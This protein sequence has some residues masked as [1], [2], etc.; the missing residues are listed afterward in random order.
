[1]DSVRRGGGL[2]MLMLLSEDLDLLFIRLRFH[3]HDNR[4]VLL[5][6]SPI[7]QSILISM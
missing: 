7:C 2:R 6:L 3:D 1:M 4:Y 5:L